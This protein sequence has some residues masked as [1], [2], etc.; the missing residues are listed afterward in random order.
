MST[1]APGR[2][3]YLWIA[4][5]IVALD[6]VTK[7]LVDH[8]MMLH[9]SRTIV[10]GLVRLTYV[11]NRGAAFGILSE[12]GLPYQSVLFSVIS[13]LALLAIALYAWRMPVQ[14]RLPQTALALVMGGAVGNLLDRARLGYVIDYMDVYWGAHHWPAFNVA[15]SAITIGVALLVLDI[16][17]NP[18]GADVAEGEIAP[19]P[20]SPGE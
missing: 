2:S 18:Q 16:L 5:V 6:Q 9:Q 11:Q 10:E 14:S 12:A 1:P 3:T 13:L 15:D 17:R 8:L 19:Q 20:A 7:A 4:G